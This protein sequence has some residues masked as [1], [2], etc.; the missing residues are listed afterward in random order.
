MRAPDTLHFLCGWICD[1]LGV[2]TIAPSSRALAE[3]ITAEIGPAS[4]PV[5]ELGAGTGVFTRALLDRGIPEDRLAIVEYAPYF[6]RL[7]RARF[8]AARILRM[9]ATRLKAA[10]PFEGEPAGA[11][12]SGLPLLSMKPRKVVAVLEGAFAHLRAGGAF[13]QFTYA[14]RCPVSRA[15]LD[16]LGLEAVQIARSLANVPPASV[17]RIA[18]KSP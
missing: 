1:P 13:Y 3:A 16:R 18:R 2:A 9:N 15:T 4:S 7:L 17:Y 11:V 8:P 14:P 12:V 6:V 5:I 10:D